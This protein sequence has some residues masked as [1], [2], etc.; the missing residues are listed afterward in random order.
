M[1]AI[2]QAEK[3]I[4]RDQ[5]VEILP[6][7]SSFARYLSGDATTAEELVQETCER[8]LKKIGQVKDSS[9]LDS[10]LFRITYTRW[11]DK[12]RGRNRRADCLEFNDEVAVPFESAQSCVEKT[13]VMDV[14]R[15][16]DQLAPDFR[17]AIEITAIEGHNYDEAAS[18]LGVPVG[19][20]ASRVA[21]RHC[22]LPAP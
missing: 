15:A 8:A 12:L 13:S 9:G 5:I 19:T 21:R 18:I 10:W 6:R 1:T 17:E 2:C 22:C 4:L 7:L 16:L 11:I 3:R 20:V 14:H